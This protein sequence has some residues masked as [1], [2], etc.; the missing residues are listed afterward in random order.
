MELWIV[1]H[2]IAEERAASKNDSE[3]ELTGEGRKRFARHVQA[4]GR[5]EVRFSSI[6]TSPWRRAAQTADILA[7]LS[8]RPPIALD[9]LAAPPSA[10]LLDAIAKERDPVAVVG[11]EPWLSELVAWLV[12]GDAVLGEHFELKKGALVRLEGDPHPAQ[13]MLSASL[14]PRFL[15]IA[16]R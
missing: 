10:P 11:H 3:R 12:V 14:P 1:R 2:A 13:M 9:A 16:G 6:L 7:A 5:M 4:L 15:R 8:D